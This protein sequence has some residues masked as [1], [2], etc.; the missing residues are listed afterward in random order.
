MSPPDQ[1]LCK[2]FHNSA[3]VAPPGYTQAQQAPRNPA[4]GLPEERP[5]ARQAEHRGEKEVVVVEA[6][7]GQLQRCSRRESLSQAAGALLD[8]PAPEPFSKDSPREASVPRSRGRSRRN[9][10]PLDLHDG[11]A[12]PAA[13]WGS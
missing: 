9:E 5:K 2:E 4:A 3:Q 8:E 7:P 13:A 1:A 6:G 10:G 12:E 11:K